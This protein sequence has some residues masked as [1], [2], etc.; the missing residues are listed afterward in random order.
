[1]QNYANLEM[2]DQGTPAIDRTMGGLEM[3]EPKAKPI[4]KTSAARLD[5]RLPTKDEQIKAWEMLA[6]D[7]NL[8]RAITLN[9][10]ELEACLSR[11]DK[12]VAAHTP[13]ALTLLDIRRNVIQ[14]FWE[15]VA[16]D[17]KPGLTPL[18]IQT[19]DGKTEVLAPVKKKRK[20]P[21]K[22]GI[23]RKSPTKKV[24]APAPKVK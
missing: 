11:V 2:Q 15:Q 23:K 6:F 22:T 8:H 9:P 19:L 18:V 7:I 14:A 12:F 20:S 5:Y 13:G 4:V 1:M 21:V 24:P 17:P 16:R 10:T 3:I